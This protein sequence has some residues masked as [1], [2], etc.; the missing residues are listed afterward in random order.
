MLVFQTSN[1]NHEYSVIPT[2][3]VLC[4]GD[5]HFQIRQP[6]RALLFCRIVFP[7]QSLNLVQMLCP[8][9][10]F[11]RAEL[12]FNQ[13]IATVIEMQNTVSFQPIAIMVVTNVTVK[14]GG[15]DFEIAQA[16]RLKQKSKRFEICVEI[17]G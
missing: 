14:T 15:I 2:I 6:Y 1:R 5:N 7:N 9:I 3:S 16:N 11:M 13:G 10:N 17:F 4:S 12:E 8:V